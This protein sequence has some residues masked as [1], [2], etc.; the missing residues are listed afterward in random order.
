MITHQGVSLVSFL[1][2]GV[3]DDASGDIRQFNNGRAYDERDAPGA[4][5]RQDRL[6]VDASRIRNY[7]PGSCNRDISGGISIELWIAAEVHGEGTAR[8]AAE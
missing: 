4:C 2:Y 3:N 6:G 8:I 5:D 7:C 1:Q